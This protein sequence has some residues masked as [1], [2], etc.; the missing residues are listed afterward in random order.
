MAKSKSR[1]SIKLFLILGLLAV[2]LAGTWAFLNQEQLAGNLFLWLSPQKSESTGEDVL[3]RET[4]PA[5]EDYLR[6]TVFIGDSRTEG[7]VRY[8]LLEQSQVFAEDGMN[9][10]N[11]RVKPVVQYEGGLLTIAQAVERAQPERMIVD[12]GINGFSFMSEEEFME[13]YE[14]LIDELHAASPDSAIIIQSI[15]PVSSLKEQLDPSFANKKLE[16]LNSLLYQLAEE[17]GC[18]FLDTAEALTGSDGGLLDEYN[19]GD[20]IHLNA[21]AYEVILDYTLTHALDKPEE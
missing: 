21:D 19:A 3:L 6:A 13:E 5:G 17:K 14:G 11:A 20:G 4:P 7:L 16:R 8:G 1:F 15:F 12:F 10:K 9:H 18:Y 2:L